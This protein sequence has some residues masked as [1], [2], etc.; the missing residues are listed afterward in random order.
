MKPMHLIDMTALW[1]LD[2]L[3]AAVYNNL[4][5][6]KEA[7]EDKMRDLHRQAELIQAEA[8][9]AHRPLTDAEQARIDRIYDQFHGYELE[10]ATYQRQG[11]LTQ[12]DDMA[13]DHHPGNPG[14]V[15]YASA[16]PSQ[17]GGAWFEQMF[18]SVRGQNHGFSGIG[19]FMSALAGV[20]EGRPDN[21]LHAYRPP[22]NAGMTEGTG[23]SGGFLVPP[24]LM[25]DILGPAFVESGVLSRVN[26]LPMTSSALS[27]AGFNTLDHTG[28]AIAGL[29]LNW[30][31]EGD[32]LASQTPSLNDEML[33]AKKGSVL[34]PVTNELL[35]DAPAANIQLEQILRQA[36][37]FGLEQA[38]LTGNGAGR[39]LGVINDKALI[40]VAKESG[41]SADTIVYENIVNMVARLHPNLLPGAVWIAN[42]TT[43]PMLLTLQFPITD[44]TNGIVGGSQVPLTGDGQPAGMYRLLGLPLVFSETVPVLGDAGDLV[45]AN[46]NEYM[47]GLRQ[48]AQITVSQHL[49]FDE[50]RTVF[51]LILRADGQGRWNAPMTPL[52]GSTLSWCVQLAARA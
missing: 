23:A 14:G 10:L 43:L 18:G 4:Q 34:V 40:T 44:P 50:D 32:T 37:R 15:S 19:D 20:A 26:T 52:T 31:G 28:G 21:R 29:T 12:P 41:Q 24:Q 39:P 49:K 25:A 9:A 35:A 7:V 47:F 16:A 3:G 42:P 38:V 13:S 30:T 8:D 27:V 2:S 45:L 46:F 17:P 5:L 1:L 33:K 11:R 36:A 6:S 51:R 48:D 22:M